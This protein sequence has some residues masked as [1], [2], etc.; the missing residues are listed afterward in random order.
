MK[1]F[2]KK[3][4]LLGCA[5]LFSTLF[6]HLHKQP[7]VSIIIP[8]HNRAHMLPDLF[9]SIEESSYKNFEVIFVND[10]STDNTKEVLRNYAKF[11]KNIIVL[12]N[13]KNLMVEGS[14][15]RGMK[16]ARGKYIGIVDDDDVFYKDW[17]K[18]S[19][20]YLKEHPEVDVAI[21]Y[22]H[23][24]T[25]PPTPQ[26][27]SP[28][29]QIIFG[30]T[31]GMSGPIIKST[32]IKK[33]NIQ[34]DKI[35]AGAE[36][37]GFWSNIL[38]KGGIIR[39]IPHFLI[40]IRPGAIH[41]AKHWENQAKNTDAIS[42]SLKKYYSPNGDPKDICA[43][44]KNIKKTPKFAIQFEKNEIDTRIKEACPKHNFGSD[45]KWA[46]FHPAWED[47]IVLIDNKTIK[48]LNNP[49]EKATI[50]QEKKNTIT[51]KWHNY[52]IETF[53]CN[54]KNECNALPND[55]TFPDKMPN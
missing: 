14:R 22:R 19:L 39:R 46:F 29:S 47:G 31:M 49:G 16:F 35:N 9:K 34:F 11:K 33:H 3:S 4:I 7:E 15:N 44:Y 25:N 52:G 50:L 54:Y 48:R 18:K 21:P 10:A 36:D 30:N 5:F 27:N 53:I 43:I 45:V 40:A 2:F 26:N 6:Y 41:S 8:T 1:P 28:F 13:S 24:Y 20:E 37:Y 55:I 32:F 23:N 51:V 12:N 38:K 17:I 42:L